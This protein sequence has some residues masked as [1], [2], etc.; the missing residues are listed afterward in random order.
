VL[1]LVG[2]ALIAFFTAVVLLGAL[3]A[4]GLMSPLRFSPW[5]PAV[6]TVALVDGWR[7]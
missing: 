1:L 3:H 4:G 5:Q 2:A 6:V 7:N